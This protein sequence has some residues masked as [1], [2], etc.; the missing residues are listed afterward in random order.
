ML[1]S[2]N[3][4]SVRKTKLLDGSPRFNHMSNNKSGM[5]AAHK[6]NGNWYV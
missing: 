3:N 1:I 5:K 6:F 2:A 4:D